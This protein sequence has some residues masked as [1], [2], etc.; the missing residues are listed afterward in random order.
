MTADG[1]AAPTRSPCLSADER[2][3]VRQLVD[4]VLPGAV[5]AVF[6]SRATGRAR[7]HSDLDL[8]FIEPPRLD[9]AHRADLR[10]A[11]EA[12]DLP[13][14]V[15]LVDAAG[16]PPGMAQRVMAEAVALD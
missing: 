14:A 1:I 9:W 12:S 6:G 11:F 3:L 16:L 8:L 5:I 15:D 7:P 4:R 10:D 13:F 2:R